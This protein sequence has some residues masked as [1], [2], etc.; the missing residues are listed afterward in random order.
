M[1]EV[2][3]PVR[4]DSSNPLRL[5]WPLKPTFS[6]SWE[7]AFIAVV[8]HKRWVLPTVALNRCNKVL[9]GPSCLHFAG[10]MYACGLDLAP[11]ILNRSLTVLTKAG[12]SN[13][14]MRI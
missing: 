1:K 3:E 13:S 10:K 4:L 14:K 5:T 9:V 7:S 2:F 8:L 12:E 11:Y 6:T